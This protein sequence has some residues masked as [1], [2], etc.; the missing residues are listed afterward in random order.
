MIDR[1]DP[2]AEKTGQSAQAK[3][4][5]VIDARAQEKNHVPGLDF[6]EEQAS[7]IIPGK[8]NNEAVQNMRS[9][10]QRSLNAVQS[11][12]LIMSGQEALKENE[13]ISRSAQGKGI[14][15][16]DVYSL[17]SVLSNIEYGHQPSVVIFSIGGLLP[18][19]Q[20]IVVDLVYRNSILKYMA[21]LNSAC[22]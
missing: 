22:I 2:F 16:L 15:S 1:I 5:N 19:I 21:H 18:Y 3:L 20:K 9:A 13:N 7:L 17:S 14:E 12:N 4:P 10:Y 11:Y 8:D 6:L